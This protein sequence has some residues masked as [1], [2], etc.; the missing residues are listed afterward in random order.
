MVAPTPPDSSDPPDPGTARSLDE[1]VACLRSLK[2]WAGDPSYDTITRRVNARWAAAGRPESEF[3]RRGTV[4]DC[5]RSGRRRINPDLVV[6]VVRA[7]RDE[8]GYV[9]HWRQALRVSLAEAHAAGQVRVLDRLPDDLASFTG[10][11]AELDVLRKAAAD[12]GGATCV[13]TG[14]AGVGKTQLAIHAGHLVSDGRFDLT[15][16]VNLRGFHP[17]PAQPPADPAAVLD[18]FLRLLGMAAQQIPHGAPAR[19]AA[20]RER[21]AGRRVLVIL[22]NAAD[23][24][25][26]G[27]LL[28]EVPGVLTLVTSRRSLAD[29]ERAVRVEVDV[30]SPTEAAH[31]LARAVPGIAVGADPAAAERVVHRCGRLPLALAIVAGQMAATPG[32]TI[33][34]HADRL[35]ERHRFRRL[36]DSVQLALHVS[37]QRLPGSRQTLLRLLS[38]HPGQ[39]ID[40]HAAAALLDADS[41]TTRE[42]LR[43][44]AADHLVQQ[45][46]PGRW[47]LHDLVRAYAA[48]RAGD[49]DRPQDRRAA[50]TRLFDHYLYG[51]AAAMDA[52][53]PAERHRRPSL[54]PRPGLGPE[55]ADAKVALLWLDA[56]RA[57]LVAICLHAARHGWPEHAVALAATL[58]SYLDNGGHP[59]DAVAVHT[60]ARHAAGSIADRAGEAGAL[61]NLGVVHWQLGRYPVAA[62]HLEQA[63]VL[64][65]ELGDGR[66][67]AR[68]LGNLGMVFNALGAQEKAIEHHRRALGRFVE[69]GDRLGEA[70]TLTNVG[71]VLARLGRNAEAAEHQRSALTIFRDLGHRGGEATALTN[72]GDVSIR[73]GHYPAAIDEHAQALAIFRDIG[74]RYGEMCALNGQ[75]AAL[76]G[77][78]R[79]QAAIDSHTAALTLAREIEEPEGQAKAEAALTRLTQ[80]TR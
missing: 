21:L 41:Q 79:I 29:L 50:L 30:L 22:D 59:A 25:Q 56:E 5:F 74:E 64:F 53:Y 49:S 57:T 37:Y 34:D 33:T 18:G 77:L 4:V 60:E 24:A 46:V 68:A 8:T 27:P 38:G 19:S 44:L 26:V 75:G 73:L 55:F 78:G 62:E 14:M 1:L 39:D 40:D 31:L 58:Y 16:F 52:L 15:L 28:A 43:Q 6:A 13:L 11:A 80:G 36:D 42:H 35:D 45:P 20:Y 63:L 10:R 48:E 23:E 9:A 17:D 70:N 76:A 47:V 65:R 51:T 12:P 7:L 54:P 71:D 32:W 69:I 2:V 66:G 3:A 67:E 61:V 72:L